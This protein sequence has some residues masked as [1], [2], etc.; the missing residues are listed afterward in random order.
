MTDGSGS[1]PIGT[2]SGNYV[3]DGSTWV[4]RVDGTGNVFDG[5]GWHRPGGHQ[6]PGFPPLAGG[7]A[8]ATFTDPR[9]GY[10]LTR[11]T[12]DDLQFIARFIKVMIIVWIVL[13]VISVLSFLLLQG[14]FFAFVAEL[15]RPR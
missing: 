10:G 14:A 5:T 1:R 11:Q 7:G 6:P 8:G 13:L 3:W 9:Y 12:S 15:S 4:P 2:V